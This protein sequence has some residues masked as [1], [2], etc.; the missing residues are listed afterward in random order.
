MTP[1]LLRTIQNFQWSP[2]PFSMINLGPLNQRFLKK[3]LQ[4]GLLR[5]LILISQAM[6]IHAV[7]AF[8]MDPTIVN[9]NLFSTYFTYFLLI[10]TTFA[11]E[12]I[13]ILSHTE[14][15]LTTDSAKVF[16]QKNEIGSF[17]IIYFQIIQQ[18]SLDR[19]NF[20]CYRSITYQ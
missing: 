12:E 2:T 13:I 8:R 16:G 11:A 18:L 20:Q 19:Q 1:W 3:R 17:T 4:W 10:E 6:N 5:V 7:K 14:S 9:N 15:T